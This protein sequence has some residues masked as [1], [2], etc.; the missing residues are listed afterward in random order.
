MSDYNHQI[1]IELLREYFQ[2]TP[3]E[4]IQADWEAVK[5]LGLKGGPTVNQFLSEAHQDVLQFDKNLFDWEQSLLIEVGHDLKY[6]TAAMDNFPQTSS[7][8]K[9]PLNDVASNYNYAMAA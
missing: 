6:S 8:T 2:K 1:A 5:S 7:N 3:K 4:I 9:E